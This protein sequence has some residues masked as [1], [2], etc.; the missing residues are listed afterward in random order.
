[1]NPKVPAM[2][3]AGGYVPTVDDMILPDISFESYK[4]YIELVSNYRL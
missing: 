4:R 2:M 3:E 1:M